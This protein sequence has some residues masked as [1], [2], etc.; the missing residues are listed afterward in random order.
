MRPLAALCV[1]GALASGCGKLSL[2]ADTRARYEVVVRVTSDGAKP[3]ASAALFRDGK[4]A[5]GTNETGAANLA[6]VGN[7]GESHDVRIEC[8]AGLTSP[9]KPIRVTLRRMAS[10]TA[11]PEFSAVCPPSTQVIVVAVRAENGANLPVLYLGNEVARTD[12]AGAAHVAVRL[13]PNE[14]FELKL[15][16]TEKGAERLRPQNPVAT[17]TAKDRDD[18]LAFD[19]KFTLEKQKFAPGKAGPKRL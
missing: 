7:E 16:T 3:V 12:S 2:D 13:A 11:K 15:G 14:T 18:V 6:F 4:P 10:A 1:A 8:P 9:A 5:G 17:F 19:Q